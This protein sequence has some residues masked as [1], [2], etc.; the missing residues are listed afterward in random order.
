MR[1]IGQN[2]WCRKHVQLKGF[3][4]A[5]TLWCNRVLPFH[6]VGNAVITARNGCGARL[7]FHT[8]LWFCSRGV[9][10]PS[11]HHRWY[12]SMPCSRSPGVVVLQHALQVSRPT[13]GV[14]LRGSGLGVLQARTQQ[15]SWG[16]WP[17]GSP[18]PGVFRPIPGGSPGPHPGWGWGYPSM[19]WGRHPPHSY[20]CGWYT[21]YWNAFL[22]LYCLCR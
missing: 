15:G 2:Q 3:Y 8:H 6:K 1:W 10:Y 11:M 21:S 17:R 9:W 5:Q 19:H 16:V 14:K 13:P 12:P 4:K 22:F 20:C 18:A 7:C